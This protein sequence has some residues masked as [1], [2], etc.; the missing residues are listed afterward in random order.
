MADHI[1]TL[2]IDDDCRVRLAARG[3]ESVQRF[4]WDNSAMILEAFLE[5]YAA[6]P[7]R[8]QETALSALDRSASQARS[9]WLPPRPTRNAHRTPAPSPSA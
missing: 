3:K 4:D 8:Y 2:L 9:Y 7:D 1:E 5:K 6:D